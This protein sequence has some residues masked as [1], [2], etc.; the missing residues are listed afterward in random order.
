M[1]WKLK[2]LRSYQYLTSTLLHTGKH[3]QFKK[4]SYRDKNSMKK[5][6]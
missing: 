5:L 6:G 1:F 4:R 2:F 3:K